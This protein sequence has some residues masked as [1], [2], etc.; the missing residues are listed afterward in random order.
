[1]YLIERTRPDGHPEYVNLPGSEKSFT[2]NPIRAQ[3]F[4]SQEA[5]QKHCC[6]NERVVKR[7]QVLE[8]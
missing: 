7:S 3:R 2:A 6:S 1:M 8:Y 5:A 4:P